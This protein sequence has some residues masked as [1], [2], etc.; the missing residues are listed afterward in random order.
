MNALHARFDP[1]GRVGM[2]VFSLL[3]LAARGWIAGWTM[4]ARTVLWSRRLYG[5]GCS[6]AIDD[7]RLQPR[8][9]SHECVG[10][11]VT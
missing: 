2:G 3:F 6:H 4:V 9:F 5:E 7:L 10:R 11:L 1:R 8:E